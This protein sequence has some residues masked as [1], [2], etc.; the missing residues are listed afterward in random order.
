VP[1]HAAPDTDGPEWT[2]ARV[3]DRLLSSSSARAAP[4]PGQPIGVFKLCSRG[5]H[6]IE[7]WLETCAECLRASDASS[8]SFLPD[9]PTDPA[10]T[11]VAEPPARP[12]S[13][14]ARPGEAKRTTPVDPKRTTAMDHKQTRLMARGQAPRPRSDQQPPSSVR[15][16]VGGTAIRIVGED[17]TLLRVDGREARD[18][19]LADGATLEVSPPGRLRIREEGS[20]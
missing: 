13:P 14:S 19:V 16:E 11:P 15:V 8:A 12:P 20:P 9:E 17:G 3:L 2:V 10:P 5:E 18:A 6:V 4:D 7:V 1:G